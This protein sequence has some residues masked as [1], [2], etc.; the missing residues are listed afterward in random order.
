MAPQ[1]PD[2]RDPE[3]RP[4]PDALLAQVAAAEEQER[5]GRL[6]VFLGAAPGVGKTYAML[7]AA[8]EMRRQGKDVVVGIV[9]T[10]GR[11][12]TQALL[13]G[14]EALPRQSLEYKGKTFEELDVDALLRR[15][16]E[17]A[18][19]DELAHSNAPGSRH[20]RRYQD[21]EDLLEA[22]IDVYST[23]NVQHFESL[24]DV[25]E[26]LTGVRV[27][28]TVPDAFF[29]RPHEIV[30]IDLPPRELIERL[31]QGKVYVPEQAR[32]ALQSFF[33]PVNLAA[34]RELAM[35]TAA[36]RVDADLREY[37]LAHGAP[38]GTPIRR[39]VLVAV[40]DQAHAEYLVRV[41]RR[42]A[43]RLQAP[44]TVAYVETGNAQTD[45]ESLHAAFQLARR[46]GG[47][48]IT[49]R[50]SNVAEE[51]LSYANRQ[52]VSSLVIGKTRERPIARALGRTITQRLLQEG[53]R[54]DLTIV[55]TPYSR[56]RSRRWLG[57]R[58]PG[59][60]KV[61]Q[62]GFATSA[63]VVAILIAAG[64]DR[65]LPVPSLALVFLTAVVA[66]AVRSRLSVAVYTAVLCFFSY[67]FFFTEPRLTLRI[68][69]GSDVLAVS[70]YLIAALVCSHLAARLRSQVVALRAANEH[71]HA[72][73][74][75]GD[76][77]G[78]AVGEEQ[79]LQ[80]GCEGVATAL[81]CEVAILRRGSGEGGP[82]RPASTSPPTAHLEPND[83]AAADWVC[84]H[85]QPAGRY[86][87]TLSAC[88]WWFVPLI[89]ERGCLGAVGLRFALTQE[90]LAD[91]Q[92]QL[93]EAMTQQV[94]LAIDRAFLAADLESA[95]VESETERLRTALL[96]SVSHDLRSPLAAVI[97]AA[98]SLSTYGSAMPETDRLELLESIRSE[99]ERL[100]RYIQ[101]LLDMTRLGSGGLTLERDWIDTEEVL[102]SAVAR[103]RR[104]FLAVEFET[105][106][107]RDLPLLYIHPALIEQAL[108]N[109]LENAARF[110][111]AGAPVVASAERSG[112]SLVFE[113]SDRGPGIPEEERRRIFDMFYSAE[114]G[115]SGRRGTGLGLTIVRGMVGAHGG[116]V[117]A[118]AGAGGIGTTIRVTL[119]LPEP[120]RDGAGRP[121]PGRMDGDTLA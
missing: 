88:P 25:V 72:L 56:A 2:S 1:R 45:R 13:E 114:R 66:V 17:V 68:A 33:S 31:R 117:E 42:I 41:A 62:Y 50:G 77:L 32:T 49:L 7:N 35:Q 30:L 12:E 53:A 116:R 108:F 9:E 90:R 71:T 78:A 121:S 61:K 20:Q 64:L 103:V 22:G 11:A 99:G 106:I 27:R 87:S 97:G 44:W 75:L 92:R 74:V 39:R 4:D 95:H 47:E 76:R 6:K 81:G 55:N 100:D 118:L 3:Q 105:R 40:D 111:P 58:E 83:L 84:G 5:R 15:H 102:N 70:T 24:N 69:N 57:R 73:Q 34:L 28:E 104:L 107:A 119:P 8:R 38:Q 14:L 10:H 37:L 80:A 98:T 29:D 52:G 36:D 94:A 26:Q 112:D 16:P 48:T 59:P 93:A 79:V 60:E 19:V 46:L 115:D 85:G 109:I 89:V 120:P 23:L 101:N 82:V 91:E 65:L 43:E 86:T 113:I 110:S 67:N 96:S 21:V 51:I 18:L 63:T 54:F